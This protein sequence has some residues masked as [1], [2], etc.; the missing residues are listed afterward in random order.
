MN[1][2]GSGIGIGLDGSCEFIAGVDDEGVEGGC[3]CVKE[4]AFEGA[5]EK[6]IVREED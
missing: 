4:E 1:G 5:V 3:V 6:R 2:V